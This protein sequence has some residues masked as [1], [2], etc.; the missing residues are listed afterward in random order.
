[1]AGKAR[2]GEEG[3][4][5]SE[6]QWYEF[7]ALDRPLSAKQ[8]TELRAISTRATISPTRFWNEYHRGDLNADPAELMASY[9]D[10]H[11]YFANWGSHRLMLRVPKARVD[12]ASLKPYFA[13]GREARLTSHGEQIVFDFT[14]EDEEP[15]YKEGDPGLLAALSPLRAELMRGDLRPAYLGWLLA[16]QENDDDDK[17]EP[18][19]PA[20][21]SEL[22]VAQEAMVE[23]LRIDVDLVTAAA[24]GSAAMIDDGEPFRQWLVNLAPKDKDAWL[25]R[26]ANEPDL[27]LGG[28]LLRAF[29]AT[30]KGT[31]SGARRTFGELRAIAETRRAAREGKEAAR[32]KKETA[33]AEA[34]RQRHLAELGRDVDAAWAKLEQLVGSSG[35]DEAVR[36]AVDLRDLAEQ[37][38]TAADFAQRFE[39]MRKR[40]ARRRGFFDRWKSAREAAR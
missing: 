1:M 17:V 7:V 18:P 5:M 36:L 28:E 20:G 16:M 4:R 37:S 27:A 35:Y 40:Q 31:P 22:T 25:R 15:E 13:A 34:A 30:T 11:L 39:A 23:F 38:G 2:E 6:Y 24:G 29:R 3:G 32:K 8:M 21:L 26:A 10:A 33:A 9:F 12:V 19:V 14:S